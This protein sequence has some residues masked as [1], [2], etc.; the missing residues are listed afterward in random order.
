[1]I[2]QNINISAVHPTIFATAIHVFVIIYRFIQTSVSR[3]SKIK[4]NSSVSIIYYFRPIKGRTR[5]TAF[6]T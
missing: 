6:E 1:M 2:P 3:I 5:V 4:F